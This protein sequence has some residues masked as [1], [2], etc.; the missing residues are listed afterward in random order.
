M[1][2]MTR[3]PLNETCSQAISLAAAPTTM[4]LSSGFEYNWTFLLFID[5]AL[6]CCFSL[7]TRLV[8][9][10]AVMIERLRHTGEQKKNALLIFV[11]A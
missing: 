3:R 5:G 4:I 10:R 9:A 2:A 8:S 6:L 11:A 7:Y 1:V